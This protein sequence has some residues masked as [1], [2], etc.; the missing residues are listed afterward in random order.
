MNVKKR[1][2]HVYGIDINPMAV[3]RLIETL[4]VR[5]S[6][7][8]VD[9]IPFK[10]KFDLIYSRDTFYYLTDNEIMFFLMMLLKELTIKVLL[11]LLNIL[12]M[13]FI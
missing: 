5:C 6:K 13:T 7:A 12:R 1:G 4:K 10:T 8:G 11:L 2:A 3:D 9:R